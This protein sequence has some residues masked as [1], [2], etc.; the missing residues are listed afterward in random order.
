MSFTF[1][2]SSKALPVAKI[3]GTTKIIY[4]L[5]ESDDFDVIPSK[6]VNKKPLKCPYCKNYFKTKQSFISHVVNV[7]P[8]KKNIIL[9][10]RPSIKMEVGERL[11]ILPLDEHE[12]IFVTGAPN[13]GKTYLTNE[14]TKAYI[15][16]FQRQVFLFTCV[17]NDDTLKKDIENYI[18][19]PI[20]NDLLEE[21]I[22]LEDLSNSLCIFDDIESSEFPHATAYAYNLLSEICKA[23]RHENISVIFIN[24][25]CRMGK[26]T[27]AILTMLTKLVIFPKS[28]SFYQTSRL[29][30]D[31]IGLGND[32]ITDIFKSKSR[33]V[34]INRAVP[35]YVINENGCYVLGKEIYD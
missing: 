32:Q 15:K 25:E 18:R 1:K 9:D 33:W 2:D 10:S 21:P 27:K 26:K 3:Q 13:C 22:K 34:A 7:C 11:Q 14:F 35:Q 20:D 6:N 5:P 23:G 31:Y 17:K 8:E 12:T 16:M 30:K 28:A 24:Q 29:L 19:V 4:L